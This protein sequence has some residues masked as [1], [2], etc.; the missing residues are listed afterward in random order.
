MLFFPKIYFLLK[1]DSLFEDDQCHKVL[2]F[3][4]TPQKN[5]YHILS[6]QLLPK[7]HQ[8]S[9]LLEQVYGRTTNKNGK[10][11]LFHL[12]KKKRPCFLQPRKYKIF[13]LREKLKCYPMFPSKYILYM[14]SFPWVER[15]VIFAIESE[16]VELNEG[17]ESSRA[18]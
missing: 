9:S 6:G 18:W 2:C 1:W 12:K 7:F 5:K 8:H 4:T 11:Q 17:F 10:C 3:S 13:W 16:L 14:Q 15:G